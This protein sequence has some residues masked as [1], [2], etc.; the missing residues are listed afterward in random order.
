MLSD[1]DGKAHAKVNGHPY[2]VSKEECINRV[3][4]RIGYHLGKVSAL[5]ARDN[6]SCKEMGTHKA[7]ECLK[8]YC[9]I[10]VVQGYI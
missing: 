1:G 2:L 10:C 3:H 9:V 8:K 6:V 4:K 7:S 5:D